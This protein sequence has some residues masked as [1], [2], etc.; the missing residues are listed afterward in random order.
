V[1]RKQ[2]PAALRDDVTGSAPDKDH[3]AY[4]SA[5][6]PKIQSVFRSVLSCV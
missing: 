4:L 3:M 2:A 6:A 1:G 5:D